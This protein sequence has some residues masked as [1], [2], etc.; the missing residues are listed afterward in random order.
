MEPHTSP[1]ISF[2]TFTTLRISVNCT[3][4]YAD[5]APCL[6]TSMSY[7]NRI[8]K[9]SSIYTIFKFRIYYTHWG[10]IKNIYHTY[11][12]ICN[13]VRFSFIFLHYNLKTSWYITVHIPVY[14]QIWGTSLSAPGL[15]Y[16]SPS[17]PQTK[18]WWPSGGVHPAQLLGDGTHCRR[19]LWSKDTNKLISSS[20]FSLKHSL[21]SK[22]YIAW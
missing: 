4:A 6:F 7:T 16:L 14:L 1:S 10:M 5:T 12:K 9:N 21:L 18:S 2:S 17:C 13:S 11:S 22:K 3:N 20:I 15:I 8:Q 19:P